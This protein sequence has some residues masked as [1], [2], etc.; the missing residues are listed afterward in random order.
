VL[1][2]AIVRK[3]AKAV[4]AGSVVISSVTAIAEMPSASESCWATLVRVVARL[5]RCGGTSAKDRA[6]TLVNC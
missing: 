4:A 1:A 3:G 2:K 5:I 6:L